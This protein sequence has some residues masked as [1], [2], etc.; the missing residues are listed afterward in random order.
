MAALFPD[1]IPSPTEYLAAARAAAQQQQYS[2]QPNHIITDGWG[3]IVNLTIDDSEAAEA[4]IKA[5]D[6]QDPTNHDIMTAMLAAIHSLQL[7]VMNLAEK[8]ATTSSTL[9]FL[10]DETH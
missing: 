4:L 6:K 8:Q 3:H 9:G 1:R 7:Q 5:A 2:D 10:T